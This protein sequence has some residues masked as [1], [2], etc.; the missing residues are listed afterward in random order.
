M[1]HSNNWYFNVFQASKSAST[2][3]FGGAFHMSPRTPVWT[4]KRAISDWQEVDPCGAMWSHVEP[5]TN[6]CW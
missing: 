1:K 5:P 2:A 6:V 4:L 3:A